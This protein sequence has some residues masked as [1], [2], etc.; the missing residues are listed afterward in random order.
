MTDTSSPSQKLDYYGYGNNTTKL[1]IPHIVS[2]HLPN[3]LKLK[4]FGYTKVINTV[5]QKMTH[6]NVPIYYTNPNIGFP[7]NNIQYQTL[8]LLIPSYMP[9]TIHPI[10]LTIL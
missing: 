4:S 1:K 6:L 8:I 3:H 7:N 10:L 9:R 5:F 2:N